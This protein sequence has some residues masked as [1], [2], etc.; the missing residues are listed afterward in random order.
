RPRKSRTRARSSDRPGPEVAARAAPPGR[1]RSRDRGRPSR[2]NLAMVDP[3]QGD[4]GEGAGR[5]TFTERDGFLGRATGS[6]AVRVAKCAL[7]LRDVPPAERDGP[8]EKVPDLER[9][10]E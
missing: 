7:R 4:P 10:I 3:V 1:A 2:R 9:S 6:D 5:L 8:H